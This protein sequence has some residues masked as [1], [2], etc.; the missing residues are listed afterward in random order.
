VEKKRVRSLRFL[1]QGNHNE[2]ASYLIGVEGVEVAE[3]LIY[4]LLCYHDL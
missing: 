3:V 4:L 2:D 1:S